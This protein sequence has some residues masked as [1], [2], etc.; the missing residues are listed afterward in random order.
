MLRLAF[1]A[2]SA[3]LCLAQHLGGLDC[4]ACL[5]QAVSCA[6][7]EKCRDA[8]GCIVGNCVPPCTTLPGRSACD[9][10]Q[11]MLNNGTCGPSP[12]CTLR[13]FDLHAQYDDKAFNDLLSCMF[14]HKCMAQMHGDWPSQEMCDEE[15]PKAAAV[16]N[17]NLSMLE[18]MWYITRGLS[19]E[20]DIYDCQ[21]AC[22]HRVDP[23]R[24]NFS[25]WYQIG[26]EDGKV[27]QQ[28]S[29]QSFFNPEPALPAHLR[30]YAWMHGEDN[31][32][33]IAAKPDTYWF[34]KYCGK[35]D[36]WDGYGG[37]FLYTRTPTLDPS[38][39]P[40]LRAAAAR[41]GF[42]FSDMKVTNNTNCGIE[43]TPRFGCPAEG[44]F[45]YLVV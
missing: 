7:D 10:E 24:V 42:E 23:H 16:Q 44:S 37:G 11:C 21:V 1:V 15:K 17:F 28:V 30:Q 22:S 14:S 5:P 38:L 29:N 6:R 35:S 9:T 40:E 25:I 18:G 33:V 12:K 31:W 3:P 8:M 32:Y 19:D 39:I 43:P 13:C 41:A 34:V 26:L 36:T 20:F 2:V 27:L 45:E 4:A